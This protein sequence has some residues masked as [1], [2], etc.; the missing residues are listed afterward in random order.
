MDV[1]FENV[2]IENTMQLGLKKALE[3]TDAGDTVLIENDLPSVFFGK[4][5]LR[6]GGK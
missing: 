4:S 2:Y 1:G 3:I 5:D 6:K